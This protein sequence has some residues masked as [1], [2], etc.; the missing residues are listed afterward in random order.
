MKLTRFHATADG[1]SR[2]EEVEVP[3]K[4]PRND[5]FGFTIMQSVAFA[6]PAVRF[7]ELPVGLAQGWHHAPA[8][9]IVFVL[10]GTVEVETSD[11]QIRRASAGQAFIADDL[12][13]QGH[14]TRVIEGPARVVFIQLP[15]SF[16]FARWAA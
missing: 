3:I 8:R 5:S 10:S 13:G 16:D 6:S 1:G 9:Q 2:F 15:E 14:E 12:T 11:H 7:V 4:E